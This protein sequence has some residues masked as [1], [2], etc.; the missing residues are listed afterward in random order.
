[1]FEPCLGQTQTQM[2]GLFWTKISG[3]QMYQNDA[4]TDC[5]GV[6]N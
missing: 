3:Y 5:K 1:M 2:W 6:F 4:G